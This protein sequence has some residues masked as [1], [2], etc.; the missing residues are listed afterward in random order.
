MLIV[1]S[2]VNTCGIRKMVSFKLG[3]ETLHYRYADPSS[4]QDACHINEL[5]NGPCLLWSL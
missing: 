3:K 2:F 4:M 5:H 1:S